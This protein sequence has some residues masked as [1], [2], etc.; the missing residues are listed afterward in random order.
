MSCLCPG[1]L[2][3]DCRNDLVETHELAALCQGRSSRNCDKN[4]G[5]RFY[6]ATP[7]GS[8]LNVHTCPDNRVF[9]ETAEICL[10]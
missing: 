3:S 5:A 1:S 9:S 8:V 7:Q 10:H 2:V 6:L 4:F